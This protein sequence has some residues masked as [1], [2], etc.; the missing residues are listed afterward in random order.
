MNTDFNVI[1]LVRGTRLNSSRK[2]VSY[3]IKELVIV[4]VFSKK[5]SKLILLVKTE[6]DLQPLRDERH[7]KRISFKL[8]FNLYLR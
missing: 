1:L 8:L 3:K 4:S 2:Y 7:D 6:K 5:K